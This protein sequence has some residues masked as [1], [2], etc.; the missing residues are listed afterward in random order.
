MVRV[1]V[2]VERDRQTENTEIRTLNQELTATTNLKNYGWS[3]TMS[4]FIREL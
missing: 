3:K 4:F 2:K 1:G